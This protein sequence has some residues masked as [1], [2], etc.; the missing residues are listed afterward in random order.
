MKI[1][2]IDPGTARVGWAVVAIEKRS[3]ETSAFGCITTSKDR[4]LPYRLSQIFQELLRLFRKHQP[5]CVSVEEIYFSANAKTAFL[6]GQARGVVLLA[7]AQERVPVISYSPLM[8][9][10]AITGYGAARKLQVQKMVARLVG[11]AEIPKPDDAADALAV[12]LT[13]AYSYKQQGG[14]A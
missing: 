6:V 5:D 4:E 10:R 9:K 1:L 7:A 3:V 14:K 11:L 2:G 12:A 13:H 8:V